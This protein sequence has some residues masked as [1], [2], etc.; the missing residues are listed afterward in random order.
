MTGFDIIVLLIVG[1]AAIGGFMRGFVQEVL[2]LAAWVVAIFAIHYL[3]TD[4]TAQLLEYM[5]S[6]SGAAVLAFAITLI[7]PYGVVKLIARS[8]G[9]AS[10]NSI[11]G[12]IDRVLGFGFGA[13]K[14]VIVT[15]MAFSLLVLAYDT[16]WGPSGRPDWITTARTYPVVNAS[17]DALVQLIGERSRYLYEVDEGST[18]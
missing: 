4:V 11:L 17:A 18:P 12:P 8:A 13:V 3:H 9:K 7:I 15:V 5:D 6:P 16:I 14:G 10:R 2:S 1:V